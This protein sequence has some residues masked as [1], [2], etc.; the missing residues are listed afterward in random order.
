MRD[1]QDTELP[2]LQR[3]DAEFQDS[4]IHEQWRDVY[5]S[6][7]RTKRLNDRK[8]T[9]IMNWIKAPGSLR[10][11]DAGC[12]TGE[13]ALRFARMGN[14]CVGIDLS[15]AVLEVAGEAAKRDGLDPS[16]IEFRQAALESIPFAD[17]SFDLVHCRGVLMHIPAW[18]TA[19]AELI[20]VT[21]HGGHI[22]LFENNRASIEHAL[23]RA[24]RLVRRG[25]SRI[26]STTA[27]DE[28]H[29]TAVGQAPLTRVMSQRFLAREL[30]RLGVRGKCRMVG[31]F[32]D[33]N[34]FPAGGPRR[35]ASAWNTAWFTLGL[36]WLPGSG[37]IT[38]G[39]KDDGDNKT[40]T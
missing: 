23:V 6:D 40:R 36:P 38:I 39:I 34:R 20:R 16:K 29:T 18:Q 22:V 3:L 5:R 13:H 15:A 2:G 17:E 37:T 24:V 33:L 31:D 8:Y 12:G 25:D 1:E 21:K 4:R 32:W 35:L 19:L 9:R 11:L 10:V 27:G 14:D 30:G 7:I 28:F 26:V